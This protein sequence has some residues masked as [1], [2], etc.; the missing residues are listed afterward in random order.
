MVSLHLGQ[1]DISVENGSLAAEQEQRQG[2]ISG[3]Q[4]RINRGPI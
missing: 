2:P 4:V 1:S 3:V